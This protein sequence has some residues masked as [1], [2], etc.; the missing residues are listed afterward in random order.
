MNRIIL[1]LAFVLTNALAYSQCTTQ[2][3]KITKVEQ[4]FKKDA[5]GNLTDER[6]VY[7]T[8]PNGQIKTIYN[9]A[10]YLTNAYQAESGKTDFLFSGTN[11]SKTVFYEVIKTQNRI[12]I[13]ASNFYK[14]SGN[15]YTEGSIGWDPSINDQIGVSR[16]SYDGF[17]MKEGWIFS[18]ISEDVLVMIKKG[19][20]YKFTI[21]KT[22]EKNCN[23]YFKLVK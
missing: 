3:S 9:A 1:F 21:T 22:Q 19:I 17:D 5:Y 11:T 12:K 10:L 8:L 23:M 15:S 14:Y 4:G 20:E 13:F 2:F 7:C 18:K 6:F 16:L